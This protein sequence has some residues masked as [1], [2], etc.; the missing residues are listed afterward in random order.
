MN[1][2]QNNQAPDFKEVGGASENPQWKPKADDKNG[3]HFDPNGFNV[4]TGYYKD[5]REIPRKEGNGVFVVHEIQVMNQDGSFGDCVDVTGDHV[6]N[7]RLSKIDLGVFVKLEYKGRKHKPGANTSVPWNQTNSY[8]VWSVGA[9]ENMAK[10]H[11]ITNS[12]PKA[13]TQGAP[14]QNQGNQQQNNNAQGPAFQQNGN[15]NFQQNNNQ[16]QGN[17]NYNP[18]GQGGP[19]FQQNQNSHGTGYNPNQNNQQGGY[20]APVNN[21]VGSQAW[22]GPN[23]QSPQQGQVNYNPNQGNQQQNNNGAGSGTYNPNQGVSNQNQNA[24]V[25][26]GQQQNTVNQAPQNNGNVHQ[27]G[28]GNYNPGQ[29]QNQNFQQ[30]NNNQQQGNGQNMNNGPA[31]FKTTDDD[32]PF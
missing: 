21:G 3:Y 15:Q 31:I 14:Q 16:Q 30:N 29:N 6:L 19:A 2:N 32:L 13:K 12:A 17:G 4:L 28:N 27:Q 22:P 24:P 1:V 23:G 20:K 18:N 11:E 25:F 9:A 5:V 26:N 10:L 8:H 7:D